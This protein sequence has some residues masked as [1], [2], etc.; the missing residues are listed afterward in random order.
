MCYDC[1][2]K[3]YTVTTTSKYDILIASGLLRQTGSALRE[4]FAPCRVCLITDS[5]VNGLYSQVVMSSLIESGFQPSKIVF[6]AG[7]HSKNLTTYANILEALAEECLTRSD[8]ILALGGGVTIDL[9]GFVAGT[10]MR[11]IRYAVIPTSLQAAL[12]TS[13]GGKAAV[14]LRSGKNLAG[15]FW[16]PSLVL[17]DPDLLSTLPAANRLD[18]IAEA[19]KCAAISDAGLLPR[20]ARGD[21]EYMI[22][23][24]ISIKK[25]LVEADERAN[26]LRQLLNFGHTVGHSIEKL[27]SYS[28]THGQAV[29]KGMIAESRGAYRTGLTNTDIS[30]ELADLLESLG[31]DTRLSSFDADEVYHLALMDKKIAGGK[32]NMIIPEFLGKCT[33]HKLSLSEL[34][35]LITAGL[36]D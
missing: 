15:V 13:I 4:V 23:R 24:C 6:P 27:S 33:L 26:N 7:E 1:G 36:R 31:F 3:R 25:S 16:Q 29:A 17:C 34:E 30:G 32:I 19:V 11:G 20:I 8:V 22:E 35:N 18:G 10:Y 12:D 2:M 21:L 14:N 5:K 9:A 28:V